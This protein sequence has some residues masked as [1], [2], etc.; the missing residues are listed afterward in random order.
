[1]WEDRVFKGSVKRLR[2]TISMQGFIS[3]STEWIIAIF[4]PTCGSWGSNLELCVSPVSEKSLLLGANL[5]PR[6][7]CVF[8]CMW[9]KYKRPGQ[10]GDGRLRHAALSQ[11]ASDYIT[12]LSDFSHGIEKYGKAW[13]W[14]YKLLVWLCHVKTHS[15][16]ML[17]QS[18]DEQLVWVWCDLGV[19][20]HIGGV[21]SGQISAMLYKLISSSWKKPSW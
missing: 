18:T 7:S 11:T 10:R 13:V 20:V 17:I 14:G 2:Q 19:T 4:G 21:I 6:P 15:Q 12:C 8:K 1:M 3:G 9:D 16:V 5:I